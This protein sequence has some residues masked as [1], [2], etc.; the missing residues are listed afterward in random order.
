MATTTDEEDAALAKQVA[1]AEEAEALA[2]RGLTF[3]PIDHPIYTTWAEG[4]ALTDTNKDG[5]CFPSSMLF[6]LASLSD[7]QAT[8]V[9]GNLAAY[10]MPVPDGASIRSAPISYLMSIVAHSLDRPSGRETLEIWRTIYTNAKRER[11]IAQLTAFNFLEP[12][13]AVPEGEPISELVLKHIQRRIACVHGAYWGD[14]YMQRVMEEA[15][16]V[17]IITVA[18][19]GDLLPV[20]QGQFEHGPGWT[21]VAYFLFY[22]ELAVGSSWQHS[23]GAG[24]HYMAMRAIVANTC[25]YTPDTLPASIIFLASGSIPKSKPSYLSLRGFK[26]MDHPPG[27]L[28]DNLSCPEPER[29]GWVDDLATVTLAP[30][31]R[32]G[33]FSFYKGGAAAVSSISSPSVGDDA[34]EDGGDAVDGDGYVA[35]PMLGKKRPRES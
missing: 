32:A 16:G 28:R 5:T 9:E 35:L 21:P 13:N 15:M 4:L 2:A 10:G 25:T 23:L 11:D 18:Q 24:H 34:E 26:G 12:L 14:E 29:W 22:L 7:A 8:V 17:R 27:A 31:P 33:A 19:E 30:L 1:D 20:V 6:A 3:I